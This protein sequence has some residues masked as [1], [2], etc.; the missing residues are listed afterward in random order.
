MRKSWSPQDV[1][2]VKSYVLRYVYV[3]DLTSCA[4]SL[5]LTALWNFVCDGLK[6]SLIV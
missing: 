1:T 2:L 3:I 4:L 5:R 6:P